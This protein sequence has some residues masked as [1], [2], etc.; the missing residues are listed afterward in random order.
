MQSIHFAEVG[1]VHTRWADEGSGQAVVFVHGGGLGYSLEVWEDVSSRLA[2]RGWRAVAVD[3]PGCGESDN[4]APE[5]TVVDFLRSF[6][7]DV[8]GGPV[9]LVGHSV[10]G[11][12]VIEFA[13]ASPELLLSATTIGTGRV[14]PGY[15]VPAGP[16]AVGTAGPRPAPQ[17]PT[18][19]DI[20]KNL[21][22]DVFD[23]STLTDERLGRILRFSTGANFEKSLARRGRGG[24]DGGSD[25]APLWQRLT[26]AEVPLMAIFGDG[27]KNKAVELVPRMSTETPNVLVH[28]IPNCR[29]LVQWDAP[30]ALTGYLVDFFSSIRA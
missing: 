21:L 8:C 12:H 6:I 20:R 22:R 1:S 9:H 15:E 11:S 30:D 24:D 10:N 2:E 4:D 27:D 14:L 5:R 28:L 19:D 3:L 7:S 13:L 16:R 18:L 17:E 26:A 23:P 25:A 29:H